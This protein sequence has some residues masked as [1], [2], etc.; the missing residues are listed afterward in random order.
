MNAVNQRSSAEAYR[1]L[2][3]AI[4]QAVS[5]W[6]APALYDELALVSMWCVVL[7]AMDRATLQRAE[8]A[9]LAMSTEAQPEHCF[10]AQREVHQPGCA[11]SSIGVCHELW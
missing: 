8:T 3:G 5:V 1:R 6:I 11:A 7:D 9:I 10:E 2:E 4:E